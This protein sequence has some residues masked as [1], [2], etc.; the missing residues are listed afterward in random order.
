MATP[1]PKQN[2]L[3]TIAMLR[4]IAGRVFLPEDTIKLVMGAFVEVTREHLQKEERV[5]I[6][7][8]GTFRAKRVKNGR[9]AGFSVR[10]K[11]AQDFKASIKE[12][13]KP[14][15]KYGVE[16]KDEAVLLAKVTGECPSCK[17]KLDQ[18]DPPHCP[19]CGTKPFESAPASSPRTSSMNENFG[20]L[21]GK[22]E[23]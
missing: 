8:F 10:F 7:N 15:E 2:S 23:K 6:R 21:Y 5:I 13:L 4:E 12:A 3:E 14:M 17:T 16:L 9:F 19:N 11:P 22:E 20:T 18:T 1:G